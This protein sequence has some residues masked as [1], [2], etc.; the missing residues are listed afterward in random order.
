MV[1]IM[2]T[3]IQIYQMLVTEKNNL[4]SEKDKVIA[5]LESRLE[6][7]AIELGKKP[8]TTNILN[9]KPLTDDW[10][11]EQAQYL[12]QDVVRQGI[13]GYA[14]FAVE[15]SFKDRVVCTDFSRR[16]LKFKSPT[17]GVTNDNYGVKL[18]K[19]FFTSIK[20]KNDNYIQEIREE[21]EKQ[22]SSLESKTS[23]ETR[24]ILSRMSDLI[25]L[26]KGVIRMTKGEEEELRA[27][28]VR[29]ICTLLPEKICD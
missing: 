23:I 26:E 9:M 3:K 10:L 25:K 22:I 5:R 15:N 13:E 20:D 6:N 12:T 8:T 14:R 29:R 11:K 19:R 18:A 1:P 4:L 7:I 24:F 17:K 21:I 27:D 28:F 16:K 2:E